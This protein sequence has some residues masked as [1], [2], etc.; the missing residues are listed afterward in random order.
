LYDL[1]TL[2]TEGGILAMKYEAN[3]IKISQKWWVIGFCKNPK[4]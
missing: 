3:R 2:K 4:E 1:N